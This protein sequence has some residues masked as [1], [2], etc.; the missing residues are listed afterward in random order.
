MDSAT[1]KQWLARLE[2]R[3][4]AVFKAVSRRM[5]E[6]LAAAPLAAEATTLE[7]GAPGDGFDFNQIVA[8]SIIKEGRPALLI[9]NDLISEKGVEIDAGGQVVVD[10][11]KA[12]AAKVNPVIPL[13]GRV[14]VVNFPGSATF[15][16]TAWLV[17]D[18]VV[19][20]NRHVAELI[21]RWDGGE[22]RFIPGQ[23]GGK[24]GVSIDYLH[25]ADRKA[26]A[27]VTVERVIWIET[28]TSKADIAFLKVKRGNDGARQG[29]VEIA[30]QDA[31]PGADVAVIGYPA[32]ASADII[33]DQAWMDRIY[34]SRYDVKRI[35]PGKMDDPSRGWNTHDCTTLGGSSG[36]VVL[37]LE[38]G[39]A[40]GLHFAGL[41]MVENYA[42]PA[43]M[44]GQYIRERPWQ[45]GRVGEATQKP[46]N[47]AAS[48]TGCAGGQDGGQQASVQQVNVQQATNQGNSVSVTFPLTVTVSLGEPQL[49]QP[50]PQPA[51]AVAVAVGPTDVVSAARQLRRDTR[52]DGVVKV[53]PG[54]VVSGG[55]ITDQEC[56]VVAA[57]PAVVSDVKA[58]SPA[59]LGGY[60]VV[61]RAATIAELAG[62]MGALATEAVSSTRYNDDDRK[63]PDFSFDVV[64]QP[65]TVTCHVGP[66]QGWINLQ[67]FLKGAN[68]FISS[69]YQFHVKHIAG[70]ME[71]AL[72]SGTSLSI[73]LDAHTRDD[74]KEAADEFNRKTTFAAWQTAFGAKFDHIYVPKG[75]TGLVASDYHIK[76]TVRDDH[77]V[78]LSSGNWTHN[79]QPKV[80]EADLAKPSK[81]SG[82]GNREWHVILD[83]AE[84]AKRFSSHI[85]ADFAQS[86]Q[87]GGALEAVADEIYVDVPR[88]ALQTVMLEAAATQ[89]LQ[90]L[91][92]GP[93]KVRVKPL[94]TPDLRG[95]V[96]TDAVLELIESAQEQLVFQNQYI[97][98]DADTGGNLSVLVDALARKAK[99]I[100]DVR[101]ILR[102][103]RSELLVTGQELKRRGFPDVNNRIR[104][105]NNTHTKGIVVDGKRVLIG[106]Q[107]WS[108][109]G[110]S[111]NRDAS[112]L[113]DDADIA[114]Y[115]LG[116]FE[117]DWRR[118]TR[119]ADASAAAAT[120]THAPRLAV[121]E[122]P[123]AGHVRMTLSE[124][125]E[126]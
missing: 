38:T 43:S 74:K 103:S 66:E 85:Q 116:V 2:K 23:L 77:L 101:I 76:V 11:L 121:G 3:D 98:I 83:N 44:L 105:I 95:K 87:L 90:P 108:S 42:V 73:V 41:Y 10:R 48:A 35:A 124:Y 7:G 15:L 71:A 123:P 59:R 91:K 27:S 53:L 86:K 16:G 31:A 126:G 68:K 22:Y 113:F 122:A 125:L 1:F 33:P 46:A 118:A 84:L 107:N 92:I 49:A 99:D 88:A 81:V 119:L 24:L 5:D 55:Q 120:S 97:N 75:S 50:A 34:G 111:L 45:G 109:L 30:E 70:A 60:P 14:D 32:R 8:E 13:V 25:E 63:G 114:G 26:T 57:D 40:V 29:H 39:K 18:D 112:L 89:L 82:M 69:M 52:L 100:E 9:A 64:E 72:K 51:A 94:L 47:D 21:A 93:R 56:V 110:V 79:S 61:V 4:P 6:Q 67:A 78:W 115:F 54:Y 80:E 96:F 37:S 36:S 28:N 20:T 17:A 102:G 106:S 62:S 65:M 117:L 58:Q 104:G 19:V 12:A